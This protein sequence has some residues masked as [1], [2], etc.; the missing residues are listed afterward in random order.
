MTGF[1]LW[2]DLPPG[3]R[4]DQVTLEPRATHDCGGPDWRDCVLVVEEGDVVLATVGGELALVQG[5][6]FCLN[7]FVAPVLR[8]PGPGRATVVRACRPESNLTPGSKVVS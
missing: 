1:T 8:N 4:R 7:E 5:A 3:L 6:V 2:R